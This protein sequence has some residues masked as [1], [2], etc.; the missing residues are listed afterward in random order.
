M[1]QKFFHTGRLLG[2]GVPAINWE[3]PLSDV[4]LGAYVPG[5]FPSGK[6]PNIAK[7]GQGDLTTR[8]GVLIGTGLTPEGVGVGLSGSSVAALTGA[9]PA[10]WQMASGQSLFIRGL[11]SGSQVFNRPCA[12][13]GVNCSSTPFNCWQLAFGGSGTSNGPGGLQ[14]GAP[15]VTVLYQTT[16]AQ[17]T[18]TIVPPAGAMMSAAA[19]FG[20]G[21]PV[22][23]Y[24]NG[25]NDRGPVTGSAPNCAIT[26]A[27]T[28]TINLGNQGS[29]DVANFITTAGYFFKR[30]LTPGEVR[31][32]DANPY[33]LLLWPS[34]LARMSF[35]TI[36][37]GSFSGTVAE[38]G[39][40][41]DT[42]SASMAYT[43]S[44]T[45]SAS[46]ADTETAAQGATGSETE[47]ASAV[48]SA[49][50]SFS[51][52]FTGNSSESGSASDTSSASQGASFTGTIIEYADAQDHP[53]I[54][55]RTVI[56]LINSSGLTRHEAILFTA[57]SGT[58]Y[59]VSI[60]E[61]AGAID[62]SSAV[63]GF[64]GNVAETGFA[65]DEPSGDNGQPFVFDVESASWA[66]NPSAIDVQSAFW[67]LNPFAID[68]ELASFVAA[69][70]CYGCPNY[71]IAS[72]FARCCPGV[73]MDRD[74][75]SALLLAYQAGGCMPLDCSQILAIVLPL[76]PEGNPPQYVNGCPPNFP[77]DQPGATPL[78][79]PAL[80]P[81]P[82]FTAQAVGDAYLSATVPVFQKGLPRFEDSNPEPLDGWAIDNPGW[83]SGGG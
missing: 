11:N 71:D 26:Y 82:D 52:A 20:A 21:A 2:R 9:C 80:P 61:A 62:A 30:V 31:Y 77:L 58:V 43:A 8:T 33:A 51:G 67:A 72:A 27:G 14:A 59:S 19:T 35:A 6:V 81:Q 38:A 55:G 18:G 36:S 44:E 40:A 78:F 5:A 15:A 66:P 69:Q 50:A 16:L 4:L 65:L 75:E 68:V 79:P 54:G 39:T 24:V 28:V 10:S 22:Q 32:L 23:L 47:S 63:S 7:P 73:I 37:S 3:H 60:S 45:E 29:T 48:D 17:Y 1:P 34:D 41:A 70:P 13:I 46:A 53:A 76:M 25:V 12:I 74:I 64:L 57:P 42:E 83:Y 56:R 49:T